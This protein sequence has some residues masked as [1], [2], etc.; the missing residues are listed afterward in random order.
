MGGIAGILNADGDPV[1]PALLEGM[2]LAIE[3]RGPDGSGLYH[4]DHTGLA[5]VRL[6]ASQPAADRLPF[7]S[8]DRS[9]WITFDGEFYNDTQLREDLK[10]RGYVFTS[11]TDAEI[12]LH[13]FE[14]YGED[15]VR[16]FNG[17]WAL[18]IWDSRLRRLFASRDRFGMRPFYYAAIGGDFIFASEIK[19]LWQHPGLSREVDVIAL[20]QIFTLHAALPP[21]TIFRHVFELPAGHSLYWSDGILRGFR[22]W[23]IDFK[24]DESQDLR[25]TEERLSELLTD[26]TRIRLRSASRIATCDTGR[27]AQSLL[28]AIIQR[29]AVSTPTLLD[30]QFDGAVDAGGGQRPTTDMGRVFAQVVKHAAT[31]LL[32]TDA[33]AMFL[34]AQGARER[35]CQTL[36]SASGADEVFGGCEI[37]K[38]ARVRRFWSRQPGSPRRL[39]LLERLYAD[40]PGLGTK[41]ASYWQAFFHTRPEDVTSPF[42]SHLPRWE[43]AARLK[44]LFSDDVRAEIGDY[45]V[46]EELRLRLPARYKQ[47]DEL[48][49]A[50][51]LEISQHLTGCTLSSQN[52]RMLMAHGMEGRFPFLDHRV[53]E[54]AAQLPAH[55]RL[56]GISQQQIL[57]RIAGRF[58]RPA[59]SPR[60]LPP[61]RQSAWASFFGTP[62]SPVEFDYVDELLSRER[63]VDAGLFAPAGVE[64][65]VRKARNG[66]AMSARD[67]MALCGILSTQLIVDHFLKSALPEQLSANPRTP[68]NK[69]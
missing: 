38:D 49:Q 25:A 59:E 6:G 37:F 58:V 34:L 45:D 29:C 20:D 53:V 22:H 66:Q 28:G 16:H 4:D 65:L 19:A 46:R 14:E 48:S 32:T 21:R 27:L 43:N 10:R 67:D 31:P 64:R 68:L 40:Q 69:R 5:H 36:V 23:Q 7:P 63:I 24:P 8:A 2:L 33:A 15:C 1:D 39:H 50:Q 60:R 61:V 35:G 51:F 3:H 9:K 41:S 12:A 30:E 56:R 13:A 44:A 52:D 18:A 55:C 26:A 11:N 47:W 54:L 17:S 62:Q 42:F 57:E